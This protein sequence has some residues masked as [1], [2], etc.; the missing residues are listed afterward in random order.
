MLIVARVVGL[1]A[2]VALAIL[3]AAG[4][5]GHLVSEDFCSPQTEGSI[6][7]T[8]TRWAPPGRE[9]SIQES[10][11]TDAAG[12]F[13][14]EGEWQRRG[15]TGS[16]PAFLV[17]LLAGLGVAGLTLRRWPAVAAWLRLTALTTFVFA[18]AGV[19]A[20]YAGWYG[21]LAVGLVYGVPAA[22]VADRL[23]RPGPRAE[24]PESAGLVGAAVAFCA[25]FVAAAGWVYGL[26]VSTYGLTLLLVAITAAAGVSLVSRAATG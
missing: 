15:S 20:I 1:I 22:A 21:S 9:C 14:H 13:V 17:A 19:A 11:G 4:L 3:G 18:V 2:I 23:V 26:G 8:T 5:S 25:M 24:V 6:S 10:S 12:Y 16:W 7:R